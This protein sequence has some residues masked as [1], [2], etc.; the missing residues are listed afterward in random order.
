MKTV[1]ELSRKLRQPGTLASLLKPEDFAL[2]G[3][4]AEVIAREHK[5]DL[6]PTQTRRIFNTIKQVER[7]NRRSSDDELLS[8]DDQMRLTLLAPELAYATGR[9]LIPEE[10]YGI[11]RLCLN[12]DKLRTTGDLRRLVQFLSAVV[13]YQKYHG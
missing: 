3:M 12:S 1:D 5:G 10:F 11:L 2:E 9:R 6:K 8:D 4:V 13:A 7:R